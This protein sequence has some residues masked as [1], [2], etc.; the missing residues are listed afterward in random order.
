MTPTNGHLILEGEHNF[1]VG[2]RLLFK[3]NPVDLMTNP[4]K[5]GM[6]AEPPATHNHIIRRM[7][8]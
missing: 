3:I 2:I 6:V 8:T 4:L 7:K 5:E 1:K